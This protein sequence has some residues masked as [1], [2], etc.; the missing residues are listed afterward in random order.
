MVSFQTKN[1]NFGK[2]WRA[3]HWKM[4]IYCLAIRNILQTFGIFYGQQD[5]FR[6]IWYIFTRFGMLYREKSGN[7]VVE[8]QDLFSRHRP[9]I[10]MEFPGSKL[11]AHFGRFFHNSVRKI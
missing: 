4:L 7:P 11:Q 5:H 9:N 8:Q 2:F 3:L 6:V 10:S 1:P